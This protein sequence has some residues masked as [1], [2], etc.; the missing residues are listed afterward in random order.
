MAYIINKIPVMTRKSTYAKKLSCMTENNKKNEFDF[1]NK[2]KL[3]KKLEEAASIRRG[4]E[5]E[6]QIRDNRLKEIETLK[7]YNNIK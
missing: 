6:R 4:L 5:E 3:A 1:C 7:A 2:E